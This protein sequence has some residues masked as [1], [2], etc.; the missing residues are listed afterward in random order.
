MIVNRCQPEG[1]IDSVADAVAA[2]HG[3]LK[4]APIAYQVLKSLAVINRIH[5]AQGVVTV[6]PRKQD[7]PQRLHSYLLFNRAH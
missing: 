2:R 1:I 5:P 3:S 6:N 4:V 7:C